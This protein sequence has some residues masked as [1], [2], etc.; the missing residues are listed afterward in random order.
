MRLRRAGILLT[1]SMPMVVLWLL[2]KYKSAVGLSRFYMRPYTERLT[3][4]GRT[5][6]ATTEA[7]TLVCRS[8]QD[9]K[10]VES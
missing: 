6:V 7:P 4:F 3:G 2:M 5:P 1:E 10:D 8:S 9:N